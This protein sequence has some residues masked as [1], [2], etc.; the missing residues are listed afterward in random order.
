MTQPMTNWAGNVAFSAARLHE[1]GSLDE[2][3]RLI[4][5]LPKVHAVG[6]GHSFSRVADTGGDLV[7]L[8]RMPPVLDIDSRRTQVTVSGGTSYA[9]LAGPLYRSGYALASLAS[10]PHITVAGACATGTHGSGNGIQGLAAAVA[11]IELVTANGEVVSLRRDGGQRLDGAVIALG[12]LGVVTAVTLDLVPAF[13]LRQ[14]VYEDMPL[15]ELAEH[16]D[17]VFAGGYSVSV[18]T[19]WR[20]ERVRQVWLKR[21]AGRRAPPRWLGAVLADGPR[22]PIPG[23]SPAACTT[24]LGVPGPWHERLPH[25]RAGA[26]PASGDELQSEYLLPR[27][28]AGEAVRAIGRIG[29]LV[30]PVL[31]VSEIRM[32]AADELWLSPSY[33]RDTVAVHFTWIS[34]GPAVA[35][36]ISALERELAPLG[37]LPHWGKLSG[38]DPASLAGRYERAADFGRLRAGLDPAGKF[39]NE[40]ADA[41]FP[42][43]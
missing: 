35:P 12:A 18:F 20:D 13:D 21:L 24:Q 16:L 43:G 27:E 41:L 11:G 22:H 37:A 4:A 28:L 7:S 1:P 23:A 38:I 14:Y 34:D 9:E 3:T 39:G 32:V 19:T 30:A 29:G 25:F 5:R 17:E 31:Q 8:A 10:V 2:L 36:A 26:I 6:T 15:G 33:H 42:A 40:L